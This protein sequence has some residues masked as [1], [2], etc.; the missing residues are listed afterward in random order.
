MSGPVPCWARSFSPQ[1]TFGQ[2]PVTDV[3][4]ALRCQFQRWGRPLA[5]RIDNGVPW[6]NWNDLPTPFALWLVG[7]GLRMYWNDPACPE[8]N[9]KIERSQGTGKRWAEPHLCQN[10]AEL[11]ANLDDSDRIQRE[12][13]PT[14]SGHS[15]LELFPSLCYS[16][17]T[18]SQ[19]WET[20]TWSLSAVEDHLSEYVAVRKVTAGGHVTV[21][22]HGRYVG[23]QYA[24]QQVQV[25]YDPQSHEWLISD[26]QGCQ[27][28]RHPAPEITR[29][30][31]VKLTFRKPRKKP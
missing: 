26:R 6:G 22:D 9:P 13:Y 8:Q 14:P 19:E 15:R 5:L 27:L 31:I 4:Q 1:A 11:Q 3:Q 12:E 18:Y 25:Q 29:E 30:T 17:R 23:K 16:G 21:Y 7:L 2:V 20:A 24:G 28:R 10:T